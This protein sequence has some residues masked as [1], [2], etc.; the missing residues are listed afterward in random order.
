LDVRYIARTGGPGRVIVAR[1]MPGSDLL[2]ALRCVVRDEEI[3][4]GV[5]LSV[6]GL[7]ERARLRNCKRLPDAYPITDENRTYL[8]FD[9]PLEVL[10]ASGNITMLEG[11]PLVH[12]HV[13]LSSVEGD[14][15]TVIG[16]H[17]IEGCVI[18]GFAEVILMELDGIEM[19]K[20]FDEE[21]KTPQLFARGRQ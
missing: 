6:V 14:E 13:S 21:T 9:K 12:T 8:S 5:I 3:E 11:E 10:C 1:V 17:L 19:E 4:A 2:E 18:F 15:I 7:L 20:R 16:G